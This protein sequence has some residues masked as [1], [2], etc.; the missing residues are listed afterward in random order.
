LLPRIKNSPKSDIVEPLNVVFCTTFPIGNR[1][2]SRIHKHVGCFRIS[3]KNINRNVDIS[4]RVNLG[5]KSNYRQQI[6][7]DSLGS[8]SEFSKKNTN[9]LVDTVFTPG[10]LD[11]KNYMTRVKISVCPPGH[12]PGT[13]RHFETMMSRTLVLS[14]DSIRNIKLL[15]NVDLFEG[16]DYVSF[17]LE[18]LYEKLERLTSEPQKVKRI[19]DSG[20]KK[21]FEGY[22]IPTSSKKLLRLLEGSID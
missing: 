2:H 18:N 12:G 17:N 14:H 3:Q 13:F 9:F 20:F 16:E 7:R 5:E 10:D 19:A 1:P 15:P 11:Y 22:S 4:C 8:L 21:F 6:R